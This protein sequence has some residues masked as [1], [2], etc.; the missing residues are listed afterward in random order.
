MAYIDKKVKN[1][2]THSSFAGILVNALFAKMNEG[3]VEEGEVV[4][5]GEEDLG[6][7]PG[8]NKGVCVPEV[9]AN[10]SGKSAKRSAPLSHASDVPP[11]KVSA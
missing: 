8:S 5:S 2:Y 7:K 11:S 10:A 1:L 4:S 6:Q 3:E 9:D